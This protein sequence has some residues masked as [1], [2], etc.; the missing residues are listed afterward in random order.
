MPWFATQ[1][2]TR[3]VTGSLPCLSQNIGGSMYRHLFVNHPRSVNE[4]YLEHM[5]MSASFGGAM[6]IGALA[7]LVHAIIPGLCTTTGSSVVARLH[8]RMVTN[9][10]GAAATADQGGVNA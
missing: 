4:T 5:S 10:T 3:L 7:C 6:L 8:Y 1:M 9:R 2:G